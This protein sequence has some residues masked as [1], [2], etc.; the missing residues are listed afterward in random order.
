MQQLTLIRPI[1]IDSTVTSI[2][3]FPRDIDK[4]LLINNTTNP[5]QAIQR[6]PN[7]RAMLTR[8]M[9]QIGM[10]DPDVIVGHNA[11]GFDLEVLLTRC[12]EHKIPGSVW[13]KIGRRYRTDLPNKSYF[14]TRKEMAIAD[15]ICG[16][17][18]CDTYLSAKELLQDTTYSLTNLSATLLKTIR[19]EILPVDVPLWYT[20]STGIIQLAQTTLFDAHLVQRI[21]FKLQILPLTKQLTCIAGNIWA[22]TLKGNRAE[23]TEYLLLHEFH[24]LKYIVP[25]KRRPMSKQDKLAMDKAADGKAKYSGGLVLEPKKGLYD[26]FILLLDFNSLYPSIIQEY[27]LCFTT[28]DWGRYNTNSPGSSKFSIGRENDNHDDNNIDEQNELSGLQK[29]YLPPVPDSSL[30]CGVLPRV[31]KSLV[32]RRRTVKNMLKN[33]KSEEKKIEVCLI[34][35]HPQQDSFH[36]NCTFYAHCICNLFFHFICLI[37]LL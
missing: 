22:H 14:T 19:Q 33:E 28:I 7:E 4:E 26:S 17:L 16:R 8:L 25:E 2:A 1:T 23:R 10:W 36:F 37:L 15:S 18:L 11:W 3:Q 6:M 9:A 30:D 12:I 24:R 34:C 35:A 32:D 27:N 29:D 31:I 21:M 13:S 20:S 5:G